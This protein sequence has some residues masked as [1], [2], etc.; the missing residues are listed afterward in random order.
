MTLKPLEPLV[1]LKTPKPKTANPQ[2]RDIALRCWI[3]NQ[4]V[5]MIPCRETFKEKAIIPGVSLR[6]SPGYK[7]RMPYG[8]HYPAS[9]APW[10]GRLHRGYS[11][12]IT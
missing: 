3:G 7:Q 9:W 12:T 5:M 11:P 2:C 10:Q 4:T 8:Q 1:P 6:S